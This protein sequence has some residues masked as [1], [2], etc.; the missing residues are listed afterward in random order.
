MLMAWLGLG[1]QCVAIPTRTYACESDGDCLADAAGFD[2]AVADFD[3]GG[4][5]QTWHCVEA[6]WGDAGRGAPALIHHVVALPADIDGGPSGWF[7]GVLLPDGRVLAVPHDA[8]SILLFDPRDDSVARFGPLLD[9]S[10]QKFAGGVLTREHHVLLF[11][12]RAHAVLELQLEGTDIGYRTISPALASKDGGAPMYVGGVVD[13]FG[14]VWSASESPDGLP[15]VRYHPTD[16]R[17]ALLRADAGA[18]GGFWG[19]TR[20]K[21]DRLVAFPKQY[22]DAPT[23]LSSRILVITPRPTLNQADF[24]FMA[25]FDLSQGDHPLRGGALTSSGDVCAFEAGL[26]GDVACLSSDAASVKVRHGTE[27]GAG[28]CATFG[29]GFVWAAPDHGKMQRLSADDHA[30]FDLPGVPLG[31]QGRFWYQGLVATPQG[32]VSIPAKPGA[33]FLVVVPAPEVR[34]MSVLLSPWFNKL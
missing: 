1:C 6:H 31:T 17:M 9:D 14:T 28:F 29:D 25:G 32:L 3:D 26:E 18:W 21:D 24:E 19:L 11:P 8:D 16:G 34:P 22:P 23:V 27:P 33:G 4:V 12:Y 20:L 30:A 13:A 5:C 2:A 10:P 7:G 15:L